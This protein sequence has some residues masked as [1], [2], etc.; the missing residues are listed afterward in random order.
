MLEKDLYD[1]LQALMPA[2]QWCNPF[3][4]RVP[5]PEDGRDFATFNLINLSPI[6]W[7]SPKQNSYDE[8]TGQIT[9]GYTQ[10]KVYTVQLDFFGE[11]AMNNANTYR[12]IL[13]MNLQRPALK[14][15]LKSVSPLRNLTS[16]LTN[17]KWQK[18]YEFEID[19]FIVDE[20]QT[21]EPA[22]ETATIKIVNRG[23]NNN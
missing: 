8:E 5:L 21:T 17:K 13:T 22:I 7:N 15:G 1:Y 9:V 4:D 10:Q 2:L 3:L 11:N 14:V 19:L 18:R 20:V 16:L 12:Q 6:G 23:N